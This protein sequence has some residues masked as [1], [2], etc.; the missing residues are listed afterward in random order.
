M[1]NCVG[2]LP[3]EGLIRC[4]CVCVCVCGGGPWGVLGDEIDALC[5][6]AAALL[7]VGQPGRRV[8]RK[9][10]RAE[11]CC[12]TQ[13]R[14]GVHA[15]LHV[16]AP[17]C[18]QLASAQLAKGCNNAARRGLAPTLA[19]PAAAL[20]ASLSSPG[21]CST[22]GGGGG[23]FSESSDRASARPAP[24]VHGDPQLGR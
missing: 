6:S 24:P 3:R 17:R 16:H 12:R 22:C 2:A 10:S 8:S 13:I 20:T 14:A 5:A 21:F 4:V 11:T 18:T 15:R 9:S 1:T 23:S 19:V 7:G